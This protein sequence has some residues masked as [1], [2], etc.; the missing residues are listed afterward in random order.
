M[1]AVRDFHGPAWRLLRYNPRPAAGWPPVNPSNTPRSTELKRDQKFF[2]T[3]S[4]VIGVLAAV[5]VVVLVVAMKVSDL[6]HGEDTRDTAEYQAAVADRIRPFGQ[7]YLPG[8][9]LQATAPTVETAAEPAPVVTALSGPQV[10]NAACLACHGAGI[11]GAPILGDAAMWAPRIAQGIQ[12]LK[13]HAVNGYTG[14][15]GHMP[16]KG[17]RIDLSDQEIHD[18]VDYMAAE[19][20]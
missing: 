15:T 13:D 17:G 6:T 4:W 2:N 12:V 14:S 9:E 7:V 16:P 20:S 1:F 3:Y 18:A 11:G 5:A 10:Y 8:E 19:A